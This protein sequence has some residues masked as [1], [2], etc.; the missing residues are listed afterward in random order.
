MCVDFDGKFGSWIADKARS[1]SDM[2]DDKTKVEEL[3]DK[4]LDDKERTFG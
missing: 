1:W 4:P 3:K 2:A